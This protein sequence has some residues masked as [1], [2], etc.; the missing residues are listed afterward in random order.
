MALLTPARK[1]GE[2]AAQPLDP[3]AWWAR[4]DAP[5]RVARAL[6]PLVDGRAA[7]HRCRQAPTSLP[8]AE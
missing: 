1:M 5:V 6:V 8:M 7:R 2:N 3:N 4:G